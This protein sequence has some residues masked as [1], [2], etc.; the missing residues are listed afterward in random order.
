MYSFYCVIERQI[1]KMVSS[2][3]AMFDRMHALVIG[4]GLGRC[5]LVLRT[6]SIIV[7]RA[8][9]AS[10]PI[11]LDADALYMLTLEEYRYIFQSKKDSQK[12]VVITPNV[13]EYKR[14]LKSF[15]N[16][17]S[18]EE[19]KK[20]RE[21]YEGV[22][23]VQ[24]GY[25]DQIE[26]MTSAWDS[27]NPDT[28]TKLICKEEGGLKRSGGLGDILSGAMGTHIAWN[29]ILGDGREG[30][31]QDATDK[32]ISCWSACCLTKKATKAAFDKKRRAMQAPDVLEEIGPVF[33]ETITP[34]LP[35]K[36]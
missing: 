8:I 12:V 10:V 6:V 11:I 3:T 33:E 9:E 26:F 23:V 22:V 34:R 29:H 5:P 32:L 31:A 18:D 7:E 25:Q 24:K 4:P 35:D 20:L 36:R 14:L 16:I 27:D 21:A 1:E 19:K 2:V 15:E 28:S 13:V 17:T 30:K